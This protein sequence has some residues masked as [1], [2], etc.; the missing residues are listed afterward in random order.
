MKLSTVTIYGTG[1]IGGSFA[2]ALKSAFPGVRIAGV[3]KPEVLDRALQLKVID[4]AGP[5]PSDVIILATPV[6]NILD[7]IDQLS[8]RPTLLTDVGSTKTAICRKAE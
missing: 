3:D 4:R 7:L 8:A 5:E 1:L 2:L 6:N